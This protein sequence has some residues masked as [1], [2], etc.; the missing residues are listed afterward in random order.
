[1]AKASR[2]NSRQPRGKLSPD[3]TPSPGAQNRLDV[4]VVGAH[5]SA[6]LAAAALRDGHPRLTVGHVLPCDEGLVDRLTL[7]NP[8]FFDLHPLL[9]K[10]R[11]EPLWTDTFG[12]DF[13]SPTNPSRGEYATRTPTALVASTAGVASAIARAAHSAGDRPQPCNEFKVLR[14]VDDGVEMLIDGRPMTARMLLVAS[15][16]PAD[17]RRTLGI[18]RHWDE[19]VV[20]QYQFLQF[21]PAKGALKLPQGGPVAMSWDLEGRGMWAW[22]L[23]SGEMV[24]LAV[25]RARRPA[26]VTDTADLASWVK[27]LT[28]HGLISKPDALPE[29]STARCIDLPVAGALAGEVVA[30]RTL[31]IGPAGGFVSACA[32]EVYPSCWSAV[33]ASEVAAE[34]LRETHV[35]D[36]LGAYRS[37]CGSTVGDYLRG[38]Q[39]NLKLLLPLVYKNKVMAA[40]LGEAI[41]SGESVVR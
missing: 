21:K 28:L 24:H 11:G 13:L 34:A 37:R 19:P 2:T 12:L 29:L 25:L 40:R 8:R 36:A 14:V 30:N 35:Q 15:N 23:A 22:A 10:L 6:S 3:A 27:N 18:A 41:L 31:L 1:M 5:C 32:E 33:L 26:H 39:Q 17:A 9:G 16:L 38:P 20:Q 7:V 4:L